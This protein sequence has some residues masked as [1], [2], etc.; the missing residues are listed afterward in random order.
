M[1]I[2]INTLQC[3][4][5]SHFTF[6]SDYLNILRIT[7]LYLLNKWLNSSW[8]KINGWH[9]KWWTTYPVLLFILLNIFI[10][11]KRQKEWTNVSEN[12]YTENIFCLLGKTVGV[13]L[14][15]THLKVDLTINCK[16]TYLAINQLLFILNLLEI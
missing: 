4:I 9:L 7:I 13:F 8:I 10:D 15:Q 6:S 2:Y 12:R 1:H 11:D 14:L 5:I 16:C 3:T